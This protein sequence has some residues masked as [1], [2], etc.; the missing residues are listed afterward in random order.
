MTRQL[1][2]SIG[3]FS[4]RG[5]RSRNEDFYGVL[6]PRDSLLSNKG[7]AA[8]IAD[9]VSSSQAGGLASEYSVK[10]FLTD[11][12]STPE[13]WT[14]KKSVEQV[15]SALNRWLY[16][17]SRGLAGCGSDM[18]TTFSAMVIKS[19]TGHLFHIGDTRIYQLRDGKLELLTNDHRIRTAVENGY[20]NRAMGADLHL[21]ID[22]RSLSIEAGDVYLFTTDGVHEYLSSANMIRLIQDNA[23]N[24]DRA[25][26]LMV[27]AAYAN[28][29]PD[30]LTCQLLRIDA[31]PAQDVD[32][33]YRTLTE[34]PFPPALDE[35]MVLDGYLIVRE[36]HASSTSQLYLAIDQESGQEVVL[37]TPS[38][39]YEDDPGYLERF[40]HEEWAGRRINNPHVLRVYPQSRKRR[41][42]Y[43]VMEYLEG[44]TLRQWM[45]EN[46]QPALD[47]V[48]GLVGQ[49]AQGLRAF[50]RM[51][52]LHRDLK[53]E[54]ILI[55]RF[56][57][58]KVIDF[59]SVKIAGIAETGGSIQDDELLGTRNYIA[60]ECLLGHPGSS[61]SE[62]FSLGVIAYEMFT[63]Q[64]PYGESSSWHITSRS[65]HKLE[66]KPVRNHRQEVPVWINGA[67]QKALSIDPNHRYPALSEFLY[68]LSHPNPETLD[69][70]KKP[71][72]ERN[73]LKFW[74]MMT[75]LLLLSNLVLIYLL[76]ID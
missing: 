76:T 26:K 49:I 46:P 30:N 70:P 62:L 5:K 64:L 29:S 35:G 20:L 1:E 8:A 59:G 52:M 68:D 61:A 54:N 4:E 38:V 51:E 73:P 2:V 36:L 15:I 11:Y 53:P 71:L 12:F 17:Q 23:D 33:L 13:S 19:T 63:H 65:L 6:I 16:S 32:S 56:G 34:L 42:L 41:F 50:H 57:M 55:D 69:N 28:G 66:Y 40:L 60:P 37:K 21:E 9:G 3:Q 22:Y 10:G 47:E 75:L 18:L 25:A 39:N 7:A 31:L 67:L 48:R 24:L 74:Q 58:A 72:I 27:G 14:V 44:K 45:C 43:Y